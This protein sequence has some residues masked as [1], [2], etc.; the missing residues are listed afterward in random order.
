MR[1][2]TKLLK[3]DVLPVLSVHGRPRK[4]KKTSTSSP[5]L[6]VSNNAVLSCKASKRIYSGYVG[7]SAYSTIKS[8]FLNV[9]LTCCVAPISCT[10]PLISIPNTNNVLINIKSL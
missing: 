9:S 10:F 1:Q 2:I 4:L 3:Y 8:R 5:V 7:F 6:N